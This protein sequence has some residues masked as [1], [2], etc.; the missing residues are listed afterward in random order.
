MSRVFIF[1]LEDA[2][3]I[4]QEVPVILDALNEIQPAL[5]IFDPLSSGM[6]G[7]VDS[8]KNT[9]VRAALKPLIAALKTT[10]TAALA[11]E[12]LNKNEKGNRAFYRLNGSVA[13]GA[14]ARFVSIAGPD[15]LRR[16]D[17]HAHVLAPTKQNLCGKRGALRYSTVSTS[18]P[19]RTPRKPSSTW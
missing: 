14:M 17:E 18:L 3:S 13:F 5:V 7:D 12:H 9:A 15:P 1:P 19:R 8:H 11:I 6:T 2:P 16:D 4:T 10:R